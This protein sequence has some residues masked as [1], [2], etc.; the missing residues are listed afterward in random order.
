M[1]LDPD[2]YIEGMQKFHRLGVRAIE[3]SGG[4]EPTLYPHLDRCLGYFLDA[5]QM[6]VGIIT[7]GLAIDRIEKFLKDLAWV[8]ISLNALDYRKASELQPGVDLARKQT[9]V[10]FCYIWNDLS[11]DKIKKVA[12]FVNEN[13]II[14]RVSPD[15][16][17][18]PKLIKR[19]MTH[20][21]KQ[22]DKIGSENLF[23]S[24]FNTT[25]T[26]RNDNCY[27]HLL[28]PAFYTDGYIYP[29]PSAEL[30]V[31]NNKQINAG[32]RLCHAKDVFT[33]YADPNTPK[34]LKHACSYCKYSKQQDL[35]EDLL[36][37]TEFNEFA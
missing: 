37:E 2:L 35:I 9:K 33:F 14:C 26:R 10:S 7:N 6:K 32:M 29:C 4:G 8:R 20:I 13:Q 25:L 22:L 31:E 3:L 1:D 16:I 17:M 23:L 11:D 27:M 19:Q 34:A 12:A 15:C 36:T 24:D 18:E 21:K 30:A 5:L 28:K